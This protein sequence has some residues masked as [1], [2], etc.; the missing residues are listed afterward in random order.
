MSSTSPNDTRSLGGE[1]WVVGAWGNRKIFNV[2]GR[3]IKPDYS[4]GAVE[5]RAVEEQ[6]RGKKFDCEEPIYHMRE[7][8]GFIHAENISNI[9]G[10]RKWLDEIGNAFPGF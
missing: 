2:P 10:L 9:S 6:L 4:K 5:V 7:R 3:L 8:L 1:V